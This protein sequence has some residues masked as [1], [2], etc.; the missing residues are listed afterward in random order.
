MP[1]KQVPASAL[2]SLRQSLELLPVRCPERKR[3]VE[4][5]AHLY[6]ISKDTLYRL[7]R[8]QTRPKSI[9]R[10]DRGQP[11][12]LSQLEMES[13]CEIIAA[14]K[15]RTSNKKGRHIS[16]TRAIEVLEEY[17]VDT[18]NGFI[19]PPPGLLTRTT[20]NRYLQ[21]WG[22]DQERM[23]RQP[24]AVRFQANNSNDC[25]HF[26]LSP[27][28]LKHIAQPAWVEPGRGNPLLMLYS[29]VDDRSGMC[30]QE[31][32]CVYG[33]NVEAALRFLFNAMT[34]KS[35][36]SPFQGIPA[37][38]Y[39]DNGPISKSTIFQNVLSCLDIK[40]MT[41]M[42]KGSDGRR[43]T[44]RSKGKV[45]RPFRTVKEAHETLYHFQ[46]PQTEAEANQWL[47]R[48][49]LN[50]NDQSHRLEP[51][52]RLEDWLANIP[53]DGLRAMCRWERF[54]TFA[55][56]PQ[57]RKVGG[58]A[59]VSV[60]GVAY[61][62]DPDL[63]G[64]TVILWWGLFDNEL[65]VERDEQRYGPFYP[66]DGPIPLHRYRKFKRTRT[67][68]RADKIAALAKQLELPRAALSGNPDIRFVE[69]RDP[70]P[71]LPLNQFQD[72][73][74]YQEFTYP[75]TLTAKLAIADYLGQPLAK[76][77]VEHREFISALVEETLTKKAI[78]ERVRA[79]FQLQTRGEANAD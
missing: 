6:G 68:E 71:A 55:R 20:V 21:A 54:C 29:V 66:V 5:T 65:Y 35:D 63:A 47:H 72:P 53:K 58:D 73:D 38:I 62:V 30:Y 46:Q 70:S 9:H 15:I 39:A 2:V 25:W 22:Y 42:P 23:T 40:L 12:K 4:N 10:T 43:V 69:E 59:R 78:L 64:E 26:D 56:E 37:A 8:E 48:Y 49:L 60:E 11:R 52:S 34:A 50:Y 33:E 31:Y 32:H 45:E 51:H 19:Q 75:T 24:P 28:D 41:H 13:Y 36:N 67:Q 57:R 61:E 44:A 18:P 76:L 3:L 14:F 27:S 1:R 77:S 74:P 79:Y 16:T 17:G 7:L